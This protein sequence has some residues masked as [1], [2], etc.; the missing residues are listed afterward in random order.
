MLHIEGDEEEEDVGLDDEAEEDVGLDEEEVYAFSDLCQPL[1]R[2]CRQGD[3]HTLHPRTTPQQHAF[4]CMAH[5]T[6]CRNI[7]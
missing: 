3:P 2:W 5:A 4:A 1:Q 6:P 7:K